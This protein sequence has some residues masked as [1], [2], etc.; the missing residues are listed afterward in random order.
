MLKLYQQHLNPQ[1][2]PQIAKNLYVLEGT[3][4][5]QDSM[6]SKQLRI[7]GPVLKTV[8][9]SLLNAFQPLSTICLPRFQGSGLH[10]QEFPQRK[11]I[12]QRESTHRILIFGSS[13]TEKVALLSY[14]EIHQPTEPDHTQLAPSQFLK[15]RTFKCEQSQGS[16]ASEERFENEPEPKIIR[17]QNETP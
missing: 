8:C 12:C 9:L 4:M 3:F 16:Q 5:F 13:F 11:Q 1:I 14:M 15:C 6:K 2:S 17:Q 7:G 10:P